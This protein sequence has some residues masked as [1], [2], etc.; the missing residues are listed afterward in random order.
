[1]A[2]YPC[3][4]C[5]D[6]NAFTMWID[7]QPPTFCPYATSD[8]DWARGMEAVDAAR[9]RVR[10]ITDC[11]HQ[12]ARARQQARWRRLAPECFDANGNMLPGKIGEVLEKAQPRDEP[13][14]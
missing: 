14:V 12:M 3:P 6:P 4:I 2:R 7:P 1:M 11:P 13:I 5:G 9:A 8:D 10:S